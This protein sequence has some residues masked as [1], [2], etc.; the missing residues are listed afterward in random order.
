MEKLI[1]GKN[2]LLRLVV[3]ASILTMAVLFCPIG[4]WAAPAEAQTT[5]NITI[6]ITPG[7]IGCSINATTWAVG[8]VYVGMTAN[9]SVNYFGI[10]NTST[11][12]AN[13]SIGVTGA[14]WTGGATAWTHSAT[15]TAGADTVGLRANDG[16]GSVIVKSSS[17]LNI[18]TNQA[19]STDFN[20]GLEIFVPTS[21]T[22]TDQKTNVCQ[23]TVSAA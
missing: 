4:L 1:S 11:V 23:V 8:T 17:L 3:I 21:S 10:D 16:T 7:V 6:T 18:K 12:I 20:F 15:A 5:A 2:Y 9:T 22:V 14:T 13:F 19:A